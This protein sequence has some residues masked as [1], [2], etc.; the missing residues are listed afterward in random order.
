MNDTGIKINLTSSLM[1]VIHKRDCYSLF[2]IKCVI[3]VDSSLGA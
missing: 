3:Q 2:L 1:S